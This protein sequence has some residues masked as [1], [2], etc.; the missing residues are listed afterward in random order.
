M[1][2][3]HH[4]QR[5]IISTANNTTPAHTDLNPVKDQPIIMLICTIIT[6]TLPSNAKECE[7]G[8]QSHIGF[9]LIHLGADNVIINLHL[10]LLHQ[11]KCTY[12]PRCRRIISACTVNEVLV[13]KAC[14]IRPSSTQ[15]HH[16]S[17]CKEKRETSAE[18]MLCQTASTGIAH[19]LCAQ[20][21]KACY[22]TGRALIILR[23][24]A[25]AIT[26]PNVKGLEL[27]WGHLEEKLLRLSSVNR[28]AGGSF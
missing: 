20:E 21:G 15:A 12:Q 24:L 16:P 13:K 9:K 1:P 2:D 11:D 17:S 28:I 23:L 27:V 5:T 4:S 3:I 10:C 25:I 8:Q 26:P 14:S 19:L 22:A 7:G 18:P 6:T